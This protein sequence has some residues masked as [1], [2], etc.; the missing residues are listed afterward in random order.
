[1]YIKITL[2]N[3]TQPSY[4]NCNTSMVVRPKATFTHTDLWRRFVSQWSL[5]DKGAFPFKKVARAHAPRNAVATQIGDTNRCVWYIISFKCYH[6]HT[7]IDRSWPYWRHHKRMQLCHKKE[8]ENSDIQL[9]SSQYF[10]FV[11]F[12]RE[13]SHF[14]FFLS[15]KP[16]YSVGFSF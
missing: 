2:A 9:L 15:A 12:K 1:M 7:P 3:R 5:R 14:S 8:G 10:S 13:I 4:L 11:N 16:Q 6:H